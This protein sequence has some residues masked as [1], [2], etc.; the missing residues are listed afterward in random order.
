MHIGNLSFFAGNRQC[1][2]IVLGVGHDAGYIPTLEDIASDPSKR[3]L[4]TLLDGTQMHCKMQTLGFG[5]PPLRWESLFDSKN[6]T[7]KARSRSPKWTPFQKPQTA[8]PSGT[9]TAQQEGARSQPATKIAPAQPSASSEPPQDRPMSRDSRKENTADLINEAAL[10]ERLELV[11]DESGRRV[12]KPLK[13]NLNS[14]YINTLRQ[15]KLCGW[16]HLRGRCDGQCGKNHLPLVLTPNEF[17]YLWHVYRQN[18]CHKSR[19]NKDC[20]DD[21]CIYGHP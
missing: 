8:G 21:K 15:N 20:T 16:Y 1:R 2:H 5:R 13:I 4:I 6:K 17:D 3:D 11:H 12:D 7:G 18:E 10:S 19:K 9:A 14:A